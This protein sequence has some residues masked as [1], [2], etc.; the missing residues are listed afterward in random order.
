MPRRDYRLAIEV[1]HEYFGISTQIVWDIVQNE[2]PSLR[3]Q[4]E[5][6]LGEEGREPGQVRVDGSSCTT[7]RA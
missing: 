7:Y 3:A 4:V 2:L 1:V 6:L 5:Q